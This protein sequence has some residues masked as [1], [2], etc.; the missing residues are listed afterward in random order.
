MILSEDLG[1]T[2]AQLSPTSLMLAVMYK[3]KL[4]DLSY[5]KLSVKDPLENNKL[6]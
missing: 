5:L 4:Y 6:L 3:K 2:I 1:S